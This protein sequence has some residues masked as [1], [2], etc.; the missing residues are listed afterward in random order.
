LT[1]GGD[2]EIVLRIR[3]AGYQLWYNPAMQLQHYIPQRRMSVEYLC[4]LHR[5]FGQGDHI[6]HLLAYDEKPTLAWRFRRI[7]IS[8]H[9]LI[10][11]LLGILVREILLGKKISPVRLLLLQRALGNIKGAYHFM[12]QEYQR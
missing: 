11:Q 5:G 8:V 9:S 4:N 12:G 2:I 1:S 7:F 10:R 3:K 6:L